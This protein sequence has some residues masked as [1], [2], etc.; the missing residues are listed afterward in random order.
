MLT[1]LCHCL[2]IIKDQQNSGICYCYG[3][4]TMLPSVMSQK[5]SSVGGGLAVS[6]QW[7]DL[8]S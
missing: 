3:Q 5:A 8:R 7:K 1:K 6:A 2:A 4:V